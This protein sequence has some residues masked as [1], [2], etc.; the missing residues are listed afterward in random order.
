[1]VNRQIRYFVDERVQKKVI[2]VL[3][4]I[5]YACKKAFRHLP[6]FLKP[7]KRFVTPAII[8]IVKK[9]LGSRDHK[10]YES[11]VS[12]REDKRKLIYIA[13]GSGLR[14]SPSTCWV[15]ISWMA[16]LRTHFSQKYPVSATEKTMSESEVET[17]DFHHR[18][19]KSKERF[20]NLYG[21]RRL[22]LSKKLCPST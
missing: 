4:W 21:A 13:S 10:T 18:Q 17:H 20:A 22:L 8:E 16:E 7:Y 5:C 9:V 3:K 2:F 19:A 14:V 6:P 1:M 15:W 12:R 11:S